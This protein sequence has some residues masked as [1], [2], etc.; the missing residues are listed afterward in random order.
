MEKD[1]NYRG[2]KVF[3]ERCPN[4]WKTA[5]ELGMPEIPLLWTPPKRWN[6]KTNSF[7]P[8][9]EGKAFIDLKGETW[10]G[11][12]L[13]DWVEPAEKPRDISQKIDWNE[14][15]P[16]I[17]ITGKL[18][19]LMTGYSQNVNVL[20]TKIGEKPFVWIHPSTA[21]HL[22]IKD[23]DFA[24]IV[25]PRSPKNELRMRVKLTT[26]IHPK[27]VF[28]P[29]HTG[30]KAINEDFRNEG[31]MLVASTAEDPY[32]RMIGYSTNVCRIERVE[33]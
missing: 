7:Y 1:P 9:K 2:E 14:E 28:V 18:A 29:T 22:G 13:P 11:A 23:G 5:K 4:C 32:T 3:F 8:W 24:K 17:M 26:L 10:Y 12:G 15:Y 19:H 33:R 21:E 6:Q 16:L 27:V 30:P 25:T 31:V 20:L